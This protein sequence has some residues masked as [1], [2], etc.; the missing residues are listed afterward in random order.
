[1]SVTPQMSGQASWEIYRKLCSMRQLLNRQKQEQSPRKISGTYT[2]ATSKEIRGSRWCDA[3][4]TPKYGL[5]FLS[6]RRFTFRRLHWR[7]V[8][9]LALDPEPTGGL[10]RGGRPL[11][12]AFIFFLLKKKK[13]GK[14]GE[15]SFGCAFGRWGREWKGI[16]EVHEGRSGAFQL[17]DLVSTQSPARNFGKPT[18]IHEDDDVSGVKVLLVGCPF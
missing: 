8:R 4:D 9:P 3:T 13:K 5:A 12:T 14:Q 10:G 17:R 1:M 11:W 15:L 2:A 7:F 16:S 6:R 18:F